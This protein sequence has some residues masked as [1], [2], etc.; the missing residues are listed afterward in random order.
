MHC[1]TEMAPSGHAAYDSSKVLTPSK[2]NH[3]PHINNHYN[4]SI[5]SEQTL[6]Q[7]V[8]DTTEKK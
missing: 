7:N 2:E 3:N 4:S 1:G 5:V 8:I 6:K